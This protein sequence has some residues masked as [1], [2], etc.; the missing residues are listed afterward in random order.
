MPRKDVSVL[1]FGRLL[2][3]K[4]NFYTHIW[5]LVDVLS[6]F[7]LI[8]DVSEYDNALEKYWAGK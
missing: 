3:D 6:H 4:S 2:V 8:N 7:N 5:G 1:M